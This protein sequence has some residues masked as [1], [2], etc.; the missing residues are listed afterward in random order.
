VNQYILPVAVGIASAVLRDLVS[1]RQS[2]NVDPT[3]P[4]SWKM[5]AVSAVIGGLTGFLGGTAAAQF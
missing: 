3:K 5:V 2:V 1:Y 4:F